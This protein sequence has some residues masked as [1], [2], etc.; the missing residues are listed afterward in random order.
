ML[1]KVLLENGLEKMGSLAIKYKRR[2]V[3]IRFFFEI[4]EC[5]RVSTHFIRLIKYIGQAIELRLSNIKIQ[6]IE[7][8]AVE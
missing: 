4:F 1:L 7:N 5:F 2:I 8:T 3:L 6:K